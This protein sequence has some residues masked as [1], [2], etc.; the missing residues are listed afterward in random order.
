MFVMSL[1]DNH[2]GR[3]MKVWFFPE[4]LGLI[5]WLRESMSRRNPSSRSA[6]SPKVEEKVCISFS[7]CSMP[8]KGL[9]RSSQHLKPISFAKDLHH[10]MNR[11]KLARDRSQVLLYAV[12]N[13]THSAIASQDYIKHH[14]FRHCLSR[15]FAS[16]NDLQW[17][18]YSTLCSWRFQC[19]IL[20][21]TTQS[22]YDTVPYCVQ[23]IT[24][25]SATYV[26][27]LPLMRGYRVG[28]QCTTK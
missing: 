19:N 6:S 18:L 13:I 12:S 3:G 16:D 5:A 15:L 7:S 21:M 20:R 24:C 9:Y 14:P 4:R 10:V 17:A 22:R 2:E 28:V 11:K 23:D 26:Q 8:R 1:W 25:K 27:E